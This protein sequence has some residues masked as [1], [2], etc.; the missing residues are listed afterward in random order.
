MNV[1]SL[2]NLLG[3]GAPETPELQRAKIQELVEEASLSREERAM[4]INVLTLARIRIE[5]LMVPRAEIQAL[6]DQ[7]DYQHA[8]ADFKSSG[9]SRM[10][11]YQRSL[12]NPTGLV[13][14]KDLISHAEAG[15]KKFKLSRVRREILFVPPSMTALDLL[16]KMQATRIHMALVIDEYGGTDGL[17]TLEDLVEQVVGEI[18]DEHDTQDV[19][20]IRKEGPL[21]YV[22]DARL[23][24]EEFEE[25]TGVNLTDE[26]KDEVDTL[27]GLV[28]SLTGRIPVRG[29][30][31]PA[32]EAGF[33]IVVEDA[34]ARRIKRVRIN[35]IG[36]ST[37]R[38]GKEE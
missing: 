17:V 28:F 29:E 9:H 16:N 18:E 7:E 20:L 35:R 30:I 5:D 15:D 10:P 26:M 34:D 19:D 11:L 3:L 37:T 23:E 38:A 4:I 36:A 33:E 24:L 27:G 21:S 1:S 32:V 31:I 13:H 8:V 25:F 14:V 22:A 12:D 2:R 6:D